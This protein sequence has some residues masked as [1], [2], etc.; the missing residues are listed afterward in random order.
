M[1]GRERNDAFLDF[2]VSFLDELWLVLI[3]SNFLSIKY[4]TNYKQPRAG[5]KGPSPRGKFMNSTSNI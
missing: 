3:C 1:P 5:Q 4:T 2:R